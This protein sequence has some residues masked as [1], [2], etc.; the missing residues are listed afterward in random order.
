MAE[1]L[2]ARL[3]WSTSCGNRIG[4]DGWAR[5]WGVG[6][7]HKGNGIYRPRVER[8][9]SRRRSSLTRGVAHSASTVSAL[10]SPRPALLT[11]HHKLSLQ[12]PRDPQLTTFMYL[13]PHRFRSKMPRK[14]FS[15]SIDGHS[16]TRFYSMVQDSTSLLMLFTTTTGEKFGCFLP[17]AWADRFGSPERYFGGGETFIFSIKPHVHVYRWAGVREEVVTAETS[18]PVARL[19]ANSISQLAHLSMSIG[20]VSIVCSSHG[21]IPGGTNHISS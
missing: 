6:R 12:L 5:A 16:L 3:Y 20:M 18:P 14:A 9:R 19:Y 15:T 21:P 4:R 7:L 17:T 13:N 10:I 2:G 8:A 1:S 11:P